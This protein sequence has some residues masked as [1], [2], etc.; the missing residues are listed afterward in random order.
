MKSIRC[1]RTWWIAL[2]FLLG[3]VWDV[4][5]AHAGA[6]TLVQDGQAM[7]S[8][9]V[10][11]EPTR[12]AQLASYELQEHIRLMTDV[13]L[14]IVSECD[15]VQGITIQV[16]DTSAA[17]SLGL[18]QKTFASQ[19]Y[20]VRFEDN[21]IFLV[22]LDDENKTKVTYDSAKS[23]YQNLPDFWLQIGTLHAVYDF[24]EKSCGVRWLSATQY[25]SY[26]PRRTT[27][28]VVGSDV[29]KKPDFHYR[30]GIA[31]VGG[32][33]VLYRVMVG[34]WPHNSKELREWEAVANADLLALYPSHRRFEQAC[35]Q[36]TQLH[37]LRLRNGG[38]IQRCNHSLMGYYKRFWDDPQKRRPEFFAQGYEGLPP[39]LCYTNRAL[40]KQVADDARAYYDSGESNGIFW[41]PKFPNWFPVEPNDNNSF[42]KCADC[43]A[44]LTGDTN[45]QTRYS[46]AK[47]SDYFFNFVNEVTKEL[48]KTHPDKSVVT[49][50][51]MTHAKVPSRINLD[52]SIAV[53][54]CHTTNRTVTHDDYD[55]EMDLLKEWASEGAGRPMYMWLYNTFPLE[56][57]R[58]RNLHCWPGVFSRTLAK[59]MKQYHTLNVKGFF[60]CG[61][62]QD[63]DEYLTYRYMN[64]V[65]LDVDQES[66]EYFTGLY[67]GAAPA[68]QSFYQ[69]VEDIYVTRGDGL[70]DKEGRE[71]YTAEHMKTLE[72][73]VIHAH[74]Q[75]KSKHE[76]VNLKLFEMGIWAYMK[77]G[78]A[79]RQRMNSTPIPTLE[80]PRIATANGDVKKVAWD[81]AVSMGKWH[82]NN[83]P[84][85]SQ[86]Q[87]T[88]RMVHDGTYLYMELIDP[89]DTAKLVSHGTVFPYD[90]WEVYVA[91]QAGLPLRQY[92]MNPDETT[93]GLSH[94]EV[95]FRM[96]VRMDQ[97]PLIVT[98]DKSQ[99]DRWVV[100]MAFPLEKI[101]QM[102][103]KPGKAFNLNV[104]RIWSDPSIRVAIWGPMT[105]LKEMTRAPKIILK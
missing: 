40:I 51:Y 88:G 16:G 63:V 19:E 105:T 89:C 100:Q 53:Q 68:I 13:T 10:A 31:A 69:M 50:A 45:A 61:M 67:G 15:A 78:M 72:T 35:A 49:L 7:A 46:N 36:R 29:R 99:S 87:L 77:E 102:G 33:M 71:T 28:S 76:K 9:V 80:V 14:P 86:R 21:A 26:V 59:Q 42:C 43:Q 4:S 39:Q 22:G 92:A 27:L 58:N 93:V 12:A 82:D 25:G 2:L 6:L 66:R 52:P 81:Q 75:A 85:L 73:F 54:F 90:V 101:T 96:N 41:K 57:A 56:F 64:D 44:L 1:Q 24:L 18:Q 8:I 30:D 11:K 32:N 48:R 94:G 47:H 3:L 65:N 84:E 79:Q 55:Y 5:C 17:R 98:S 37:V 20:T 60:H 23:N 34:Y 95:N 70:N 74:S 62:A 103:V 38:T 104:A 83:S 91:D 97:C